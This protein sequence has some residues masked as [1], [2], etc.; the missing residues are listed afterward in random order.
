LAAASLLFLGSIFCLS[1][2]ST[3]ANEIDTDVIYAEKCALCHGEDGKGS[4]AGIGFGVKDFTDKELQASRTDEEFRNSITNGNPE[5]TNYIP[6]GGMLS[7][8][9]IKAMASCVRKFAE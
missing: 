8:E 7:E 2:Q 9:E 3:Y 6:F 1:L 5:N 4:K